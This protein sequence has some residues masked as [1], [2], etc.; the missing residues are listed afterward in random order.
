MEST[1]VGAFFYS[2]YFM[3]NR[4]RN[5]IKGLSEVSKF[6]VR[7]LYPIL[8]YVLFHFT[9]HVLIGLELRLTQFVFILLWGLIEWQLFL[10]KDNN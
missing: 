7:L 2:R 9:I 5:K 4:L 6:V 8:L 3:I 1:I 10:K